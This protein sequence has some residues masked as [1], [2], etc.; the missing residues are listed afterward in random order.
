MLPKFDI[1]TSEQVRLVHENTIQI[2]E[3][4][5]VEFSFEPALEVFRSQGL[6]VEGHRVF[7]QRDFV[8]EMVKKAP[9][10]FT[11]H[12]RNPENNVV[13]G[14]DNIIYMPGYGAPFVHQADGTRR[15]ATM[16]DYDNFIKLAGASKN[17][18]MTGGN[19]VEPSD[20]DD[21]IR[22]LKMMYSHIINSDK[23]FMGSASGA[24]KAKDSIELAA[25]LFGGKDVIKEKPA[26][27]CLINSVTPLKYDDRMLEALMVYAEA[28]QPMVIAALVMAGST[29]PATLA[30]SLAVQNAEVLAGITLTQCI[31]PGTPVVY[32]ST[33]AIT[34]MATGSL[35]IG[36]PECALFNS[37]SAQLARFYGVPSRGGGGLTDAK[38]ADTQAGYESMMT[39][40]AAS[41][42]GNNFVLHSAGILQYYMAMSFEKLMVDDE[43]A[44]MVLRYIRGID[45]AEE[46]FAF[47][48]I[49]EV[50]P[51][52]HFLTQKHTRKNHK[53]ELRRAELSDRQSYDGWA[54]ERTD[55]NQRAHKRW[56]DVL[57]SYVPPALDEQLKTALDEFIAKRSAEVL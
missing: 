52:G 6:K 43:I 21:R 55:T 14:R 40:L 12:A 19:V 42:T 16:A 56:Q 13:C 18:H 45:F 32:G 44:G 41:T 35:A 48:I 2:L 22:H 34:D 25:I 27:I 30:G 51:G 29:G 28:G 17:L 9:A 7:F 26:I 11:L 23:C 39:L 38:T 3:E 36:N 53:V 10:E 24:E 31:N 1:L 4:I 46:K 47:D 5:G 37:A 57:A 20:V 50:G 49:R 33:S 8:E 54:K 15:N